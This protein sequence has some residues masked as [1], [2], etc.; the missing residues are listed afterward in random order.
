[1]NPIEKEVEKLLDQVCVDLGFCLPPNVK[2]RLIKFP[3]KTS[4]KFTKTLIE[5][6]G[7]TIETIDKSLYKQLF[8]KIDSV[9][10]KYT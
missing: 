2:S 10:S 4:E 3:P 6:E 9:Y 8:D 5:V 1:M 7:F